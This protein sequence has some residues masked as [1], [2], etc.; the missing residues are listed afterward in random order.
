VPQVAKHPECKI[1]VV[2]DGSHD[3]SYAEV[4]R[5]Y[6]TVV[7]YQPIAPRVGIPAARNIAARY[8]DRAFLVFIDDDCVAPPF[9]LDWLL[10]LIET[11]PELD[12]IAG[13]TKPLLPENRSFFAKVQKVFDLYP[14]PEKRPGGMRFVT[15]N[16]AIRRSLFMSLGGFHSYQDGPASG[17]DTDLSDRVCRTACA[18]RLDP[19]WYV[20]HDVGEPV[21]SCM[22]RYWRYGYAD[23]WLNRFARPADEQDPSG[24]TFE[25]IMIYM[26]R[27]IGANMIRARIFFPTR[28]QQCRAALLASLVQFGYFV[29][30]RA[31]ARAKPPSASTKKAM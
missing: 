18:R 21:L 25:P 17:S 24:Q 16:V 23:T 12:V 29:G 28:T 13:I 30:R 3:A 10:A 26:R 2:N 19:D 7:C 15:A 14:N 22:R 11:E 1:V 31:G 4:M 27:T 5:W 8:A 20:F 6:E 9:W